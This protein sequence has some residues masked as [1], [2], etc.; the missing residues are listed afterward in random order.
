MTDAQTS[1]GYSIGQLSQAMA[2]SGIEN[3]QMFPISTRHLTGMIPSTS[4]V[5]N[6]TQVIFMEF[7]NRFVLLVT[8]TG[9]IGSLSMASVDVSSAAQQG[10]FRS[11]DAAEP[12]TTIKSLLGQRDSP[13]IHSLASHIVAQISRSHQSGNE[14]PLLFGLS[15]ADSSLL[16][17]NA[18]LSDDFKH[19]FQGIVGIIRELGGVF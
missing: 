8:Q 11:A 1:S 12:S 15:L 7:A 16:D 10:M 2:S 3:T 9:K 18:A 14:R 13:L 5:C 4:G 6:P 17:S 19:T